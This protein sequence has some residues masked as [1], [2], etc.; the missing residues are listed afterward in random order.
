MDELI[1][2]LVR[3]YLLLTVPS[4]ASTRDAEKAWFSSI[5]VGVNKS[6]FVPIR[7]DHPND[8]VRL[9]FGGSF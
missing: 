6:E 9:R 4:D 5:S 2:I 8:E 3:K 7:I 1:L